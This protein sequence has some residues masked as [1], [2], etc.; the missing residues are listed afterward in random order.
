MKTGQA[1]D[2]NRVESLVTET[3]KMQTMM[4]DLRGQINDLENRNVILERQ[5]NDL[6]RQHEEVSLVLLQTTK[7]FTM[8]FMNFV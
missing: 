4:N 7:S 8:F 3:K 5:Y 2:Q 6:L 1:K